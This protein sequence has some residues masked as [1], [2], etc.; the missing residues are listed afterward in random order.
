[1]WLCRHGK[2][3]IPGTMIIVLGCGDI[4]KLHY[5]F[6]QDLNGKSQSI[7]AVDRNVHVCTP[8][9]IKQSMYADY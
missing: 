5:F 9:D 3:M 7:N 6:P 8:C 2:L 1:M 4:V